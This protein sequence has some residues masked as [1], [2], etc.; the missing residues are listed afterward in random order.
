MIRTL[1]YLVK[2]LMGIVLMLLAL[3]LYSWFGSW[4]QAE[5]MANSNVQPDSIQGL[6]QYGY[7]LVSQPASILAKEAALKSNVGNDLACTNCHLDGGTREGAMS[8]SGIAQRFPQF[9]GRENKIGALEERINGCFERSMH[10]R[11]LLVDSKEMRAIVAYM[12][13]LDNRAPGGKPGLVDFEIPNVIADPAKGAIIYKQHCMECHSEGGLGKLHQNQAKGYEYPPLAGPGSYNNGAGMHR[14]LTAA[15]FIRSNMPY[16][17]A[18]RDNPILS[19]EEAL[20]VAAYINSL[21]RP[22]K[23]NLEHDF[24]DR[25]LKPVSTPYGPWADDFPYEQH[26]YGP[27]PPMIEFYERAFGIRKTK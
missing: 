21:D 4:P 8:W 11:P 17:K 22:T 1:E 24:P 14:V 10:G 12:E 16:N 25:K 19:E 23:A 5:Q 2:L 6:V 15:Q 20:H 26:K 3:I 7:Q 18:T 27:F 9:R 13:S